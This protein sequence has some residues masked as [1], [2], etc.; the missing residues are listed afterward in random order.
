MKHLKSKLAIFF[1]LLTILSAN[2]QSKVKVGILIGN[3]A[4]EIVENS[5]N[6]Q[7]LKLS[8]QA[9][10]I[11][12][13]DFW[14]S[15]CRPCRA[16]NPN[17]VKA[18]LAYKDKGFDVFGVS[19]DQS[20]E[21]WLKAIVNDKLTWHHVSDLKYWKNEAGKLYGI[22]SIPHSV[23]IDKDGKII[24]HNLRGA[25]LLKKLDEIFSKK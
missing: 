5:V 14:A 10:K 16:E 12:L 11:V 7:P 15:W 18:Y 21:N 13:I 9:G 22:N 23:L 8:S 24:A 19:F 6:L 17:V 20:K 3:K 4:P 2:C 1:M 25:D